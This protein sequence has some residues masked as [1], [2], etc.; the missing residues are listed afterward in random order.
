MLAGDKAGVKDDGTGG[1][2]TE[3]I[4]C[5]FEGDGTPPLGVF[6]N[7]DMADALTLGLKTIDHNSACG[8][9]LSLTKIDRSETK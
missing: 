7:E 3:G 2:A 6:D 1:I 5:G 9:A 4:G 8:C